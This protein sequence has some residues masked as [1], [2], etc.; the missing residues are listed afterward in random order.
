MTANSVLKNMFKL[1]QKITVYIPATINID[2]EID[3]TEY[4]NRA[5][6]LLSECFGGA[7]S[8]QAVGYWV[9]PEVGLV[10]ENTTQVFAY[11]ADEDLKKHLDK[12]VNFCMEIKEELKQDAVALEL[13]NEMFFIE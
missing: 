1:S 5:A 8:C 3:N 10:K 9:S 2:Q 13:N 6:T 11:A 7:T 12:V 4:V